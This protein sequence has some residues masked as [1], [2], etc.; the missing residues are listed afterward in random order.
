MCVRQ[1]FKA[2]P[3]EDFTR[4]ITRILVT[5]RRVGVYSSTRSVR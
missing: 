4:V 5:V 2:W 3:G 1:M